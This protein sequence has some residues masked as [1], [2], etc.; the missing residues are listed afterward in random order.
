MVFIPS[1]NELDAGK[2]TVE[3]TK[4]PKAIPE[5]SSLVFGQ[6][7]TDHML[8]IPWNIST[9][10]GAPEIKPYAP[11][12]L[13]PAS[14]VLHYAATLFEGLKAYKDT[15]GRTRLFRPDLNLKRML[16]GAERMAFPTFDGEV[17]IELIKK[18][19]KI[20]DRW[21]P[22]DPGCSLYLR[23]TMI[24]TRASLGVGPSTEVL[25]YVI[26]S[27]VA[28]YY[29]SGAK[30]V[31]LLASTRDVRA[32][33]GGSGSY[34][35]GSN[36]GPN[37]S[38]QMEAAKQ[39]YQQILWLYG[40]VVTEVGMMNAVVAL[41][42]EDGTVELVTPPLTDGMILPGVTRDSV[43]A[44]ARAH[45]D[46]STSFRM[47]GLP[48][49]LVVSEREI[50]MTEVKEAQRAG[51]LLEC[52]GTG[53]AAIITSVERIGH[54]GEDVKIPVEGSTG[55]GP[56]AEAMYNTLQAIQYGDV[57]RSNWSVLV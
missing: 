52:F 10:W 25:L 12:P 55:F 20:D 46:P 39:G 41:Q 53:T 36:Y 50:T 26:M 44:L 14:T 28:K 43:L 21:V 24:G 33:P 38:T 27:P 56:I 7:L 48:E 31:S 13:D 30:P 17:L 18:L 42:K 49:R 1:A 9:G 4:S 40:D 54:N 32:W 47:E 5:S 19:I 6:T 23:P 11:L 29:S 2:L 34:K 51:K 3:L 22:T 15:A 37:V 35:F 57:A 16:R 45:A 8:C